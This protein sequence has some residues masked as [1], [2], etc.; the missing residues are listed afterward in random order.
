MS[1]GDT[2]FDP[3]QNGRR[4]DD[5]NG[6]WGKAAA[7][8]M[9][10]NWIITLGFAVFLMLGFGFKT[11]KDA[12]AELKEAIEGVKT[13]TEVNKKIAADG[14]DTVRVRLNESEQERRKLQN[15]LEAS[16]IAQCKSLP[17]N[18]VQYL[19]CRRLYREWGIE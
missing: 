12:F 14:L 6:F 4:R 15:L 7:L 11:P 19:P 5:S 10:Y 3:M 9:K 1:G 16:V 18:A 8:G 2:Y 17:R 13:T